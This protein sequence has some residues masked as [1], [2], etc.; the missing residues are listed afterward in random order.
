MTMKTRSLFAWIAPFAMTVLMAGPAHATLIAGWDFS[1]YISGGGFLSIDGQTLTN[2]LAANYATGNLIGDAALPYGTMYINGLFGS[3]LVTPVGNGSEPWL[4]VPG[5]LSANLSA[6]VLGGN[7]LEFDSLGNL[8]AAGQDN[9]NLLRMSALGLV[10]VVF[11]ANSVGLPGTDWVL[12]F[13]GR[14]NSQPTNLTVEFSPSGENYLAAT[15]APIQLLPSTSNEGV[16]FEI[17]L[18]ANGSD[19]MFVRLRFDNSGQGN[20]DNLALNANA[21]PEPATGLL[22]AAG[23]VGLAACRRRSA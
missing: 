8:I 18:T 14:S 1:Q 16:R 6:P 11:Q 12:S 13:G 19:S 23:L 17:A 2:T 21:I 7:T 15:P 20:L 22:L 4:P 9:A 5:S 3:S 10:D